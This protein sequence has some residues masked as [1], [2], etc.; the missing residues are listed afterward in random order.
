MSR[1]YQRELDV[2]CI[3]LLESPI[4]ILTVYS[5]Y[6]FLGAP[7]QNENFWILHK[8]YLNTSI[9][10]WELFGILLKSLDVQRVEQ[11]TEWNQWNPVQEETDR[12]LQVPAFKRGM[13]PSASCWWWV[14]QAFVGAPGDYIQ[15]RNSAV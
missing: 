3:Y 10:W 6:I 2:L 8:E 12:M 15:L 11:G 1:G 4:V 7:L 5:F 14:Q 9:A 13:S